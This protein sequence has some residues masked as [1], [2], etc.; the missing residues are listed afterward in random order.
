MLGAGGLALATEAIALCGF[1]QVTP[2]DIGDAQ[3]A[4][5]VADPTADRS[6]LHQDL[7]RISHPPHTRKSRRIVTLGV[8]IRRDLAVSGRGRS[9]N[10][11]V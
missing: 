1:L 2:A 8:T 3:V 11:V 4:L 9:V 7:E 5:L 10:R 6:R